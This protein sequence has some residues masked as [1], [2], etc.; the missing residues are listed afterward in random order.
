MNPSNR[1]VIPA[2]L[3]LL[4]VSMDAQAAT[5]C[6]A[7]S[8]DHVG[9]CTGT[10]LARKTVREQLAGVPSAA[11]RPA[12]PWLDANLLATQLTGALAQGAL[13][14]VERSP[15]L[16]LLLMTQAQYTVEPRSGDVQVIGENAVEPGDLPQ[17]ALI[18]VQ[19]PRSGKP[20][21]ALR[22]RLDTSGWGRHC[23]SP[24][25]SGQEASALSSDAYSALVEPVRWLPL[26]QG[27][28]IL[29][30]GLSRQEGY[31]G[32]GGSF[33]AVQLID[34]S[35]D[36][37][38]NLGCFATGRYQMFGGNW[39]ADGTREHPESAASWTLRLQRNGSRYPPIRF[40]PTTPNTPAMTLQWHAP[41]GRYEVA[42]PAVKRPR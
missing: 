20:V 3:V 26:S 37:P 14:P 33:S 12:P 25:D 16:W 29:S 32:G 22:A 24:E 34:V 7:R 35:T 36:P 19:V 11:T 38:R 31:A 23:P 41:S 21:V 17:A 6:T 28:R 40:H 27:H 4:A 10:A 15:R 1:V 39:N 5:A 18:E 30:V 2:V 8:I 9:R 42:K 13:L